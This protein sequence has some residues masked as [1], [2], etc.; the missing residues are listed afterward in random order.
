[1]VPVIRKCPRRRHVVVFDASNKR[2]AAIENHM[3]AAL[4][5]ATIQPER[6]SRTQGCG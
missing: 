5:R 4:Q 6:M 3:R 2:R 1:M